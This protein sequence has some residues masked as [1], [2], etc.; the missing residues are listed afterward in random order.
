MPATAQKVTLTL[1]GG[2]AYAGKNR[3]L[4]LNPAKDTAMTNSVTPSLACG[5]PACTT[6]RPSASV[7]QR[8]RTPAEARH[9]AGPRQGNLRLSLF[10]AGT[11]RPGDQVTL[12][13]VSKDGLVAMRGSA[14]ARANGSFIIRATLRSAFSEDGD[15][16][17][18][19]AGRYAVA[20][21]EGS[22]TVYGIAQQDTHVSLA[23]P[24]F[25]LKRK[26]GGKLH[27]A[28]RVPGADDHVRVA[29]KLGNETLVK[30]F[31]N[32]RGRYF[33]TIVKP[34]ATGNLRVVASVPGADTA[35]SPAKPLS[36]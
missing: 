22:A 15:L 13:G 33:K 29:I 30:G 14:S 5:Q 8:E 34:S 24:Q 23:Q 1:P 9:A 25:V 18:P 3:A 21:V 6:L 19:A 20:S 4:T 28:V 35:I 11:A 31:V 26:P 7:E 10:A 17:L 27:F 36:R 16:A 2:I 32:E 12:Q